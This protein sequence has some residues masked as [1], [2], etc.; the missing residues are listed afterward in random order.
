[1]KTPHIAPAAVHATLARHMLADGYDLVLDLEKS[2]GRRLH[3]SRSGRD[4]LDL[5]S[6]FATLPIGFNHPKMKDPEFLAKLTRA[7]L[8]NPT[9]SDIYST[10]FAEF[11]EVFGRVAMRPHLP[12]AFFVAGGALGVE[13]ACKAAMDW[14]VR[15]NFRKGIKEEKGHQILHFRE[16]FHGRTGYTVSMTNTADARKHQYFAKFDWPRVSNPYLQFP[17]TDA[18][19]ARVRKA[20]AV[21]LTEIRQA[22]AERRDDIAAIL[23]EP[24]QAEGGDHH[25]RTEFLAALRA[26]AHEHDALLIFDE[27]QTGVGMTGSFWAHEQLGVEPDL[28]AFGKKMQVCGMLGGGRLEDEPDNVFK[29]SSRVNSTWGGNLVDMVRCMRYLEI[30]E[31]EGL[32]KHSATVGAHLLGRL[33]NLQSAMPDV[34]SNARGRGLMCAIDLPDTDARNRVADKA[35]DLGLMIL[36][37]GHRSLRFRPP[38]DITSAEI[39]EALGLLTKATEQTQRKSA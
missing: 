29:V 22:F 8:V 33:E 34:L 10:E 18:E 12:H 15:Q 5:F 27:V 23:L 26:V 6:F 30:I 21:S 11:V 28:L 24:I 14:K 35:Y 25:F 37:C 2:Q 16:A 1:M 4:Y 3:D 32:V 7:A 38:L 20:E 13:N 39:D 36:G 17:V 19:L 31:E 9:N